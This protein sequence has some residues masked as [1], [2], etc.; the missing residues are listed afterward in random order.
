MNCRSIKNKTDD[1]HA[2]LSLTQPTVVLGTE[3]WL[4][5]NICDNEVFSRDYTCYRKDRNS[6]GG[7]VFILVHKTIR[8]C[9]IDVDVGQC[10]SV[11]CQIKLSNGKTLSVC[12]FYRPPGSPRAILTE[13]YNVL[14]SIEADH[15]VIGGD[16]NLPEIN[17]KNH[18]G[19]NVRLYSTAGKDIIDLLQNFAL[20]QMVMEPTREG[21][22]LDLLLT[23]QPAWVKSTLTVPG[24]SDHKAVL[25]EMTVTYEKVPLAKC[26]KRFNYARANIEGIDLALHTYFPDFQ[27]LSET[28][29]MNDLWLNF[30]FKMLQIRDPFVPSRTQSA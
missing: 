21:N 11:W 16:F 12:S 30:K 26:R 6:H 2:L 4:D 19:T 10:E 25:C 29:I 17:W 1:F 14:G 24:I 7:G 20:T 28:L 5:G 15:L 27:A 13:F 18:E 9:Q 22:V 23:T 3:S 8:S